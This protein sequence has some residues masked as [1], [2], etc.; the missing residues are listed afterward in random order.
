MNSNRFFLIVRIF[1]EGIIWILI[2]IAATLDQYIKKYFLFWR[3]SFHQCQASSSALFLSSLHVMRKSIPLTTRGF[4]VISIEIFCLSSTSVLRHFYVLVVFD[5]NNNYSGFDSLLTLHSQII[6]WY[7]NVY[8]W[9]KIIDKYT[10][11]SGIQNSR[12]Y[13]WINY[14]SFTQHTN[15]YIFYYRK[16]CISSPLPLLVLA[17]SFGNKQATKTATT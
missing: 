8:H 13:V 3:F 6:E 14:Y 4:E 17:L 5:G 1:M 11:D 10:L 9:K 7:L 15:M 16:A 2:Q 12:W